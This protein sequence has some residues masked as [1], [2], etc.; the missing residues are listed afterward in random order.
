MSTYG[1]AGRIAL[2]EIDAGSTVDGLTSLLIVCS[3][4]LIPIKRPC[5]SRK[6]ASPCVEKWSGWG[7]AGLRASAANLGSNPT[8]A[9]TGPAHSELWLL[10]RGDVVAGYFP[11]AREV[12]RLYVIRAHHEPILDSSSALAGAVGF[13]SRP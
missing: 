3:M 5:L 13:A 4:A 12:G 10:N 7:S 8:A 2:N 9:H 6:H 1:P 11:N